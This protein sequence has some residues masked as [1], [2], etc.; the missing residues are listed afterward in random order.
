MLFRSLCNV[1]R[2]YILP[3]GEVIG[4]LVPG[5]YWKVRNNTS[6]DNFTTGYLIIDGANNN[7]LENNKAARNGTYD[8]ELTGDSYRYGFLTP[9]CFNN[10]VN[11]MAGQTVKNCGVNNSVN[12]GN[13]VNNA[14]DP[15]N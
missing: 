11:V 1:P 12:G 8:V 9:K 15:C 2:G 6:T 5:A 3:S 13:L 14:T 7:V 4:S 10:T